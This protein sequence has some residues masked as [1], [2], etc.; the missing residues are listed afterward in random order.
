MRYGT[1]VVVS[2][3]FGGEFKIVNTMK[4]NQITSLDTFAKQSTLNCLKMFSRSFSSSLNLILLKK[5]KKEEHKNDQNTKKEK[6]SQ[7]EKS[8]K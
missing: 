8:N 3:K 1:H 6:K 2:A 5:S 4:K 7:N